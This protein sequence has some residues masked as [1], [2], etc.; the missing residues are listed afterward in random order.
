YT[1]QAI[2]VTVTTVPA[3]LTVSMTYDD[4]AAAPTNAGAYAVRAVVMDSNYSGSVTNTLVIAPAAQNITFGNL[5]E[6]VVGDAPYT[7]TATADSGLPVTFNTSDTSIASTTG[8]L[9]KLWRAG[10]TQITASQNGNGN[11]LAATA[12]TQVVMVTNVVANL[13]IGISHNGVQTLPTDYS[14]TNTVTGYTNIALVI[15]GNPNRPYR[16]EYLTDLTHTNW[17]TLTLISNLP[18]ATYQVIDPVV[19]TGR[20]YRL[21][22]PVWAPTP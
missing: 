10:T 8:N 18:A 13:T 9:L 1:G 22:H 19:P 17:Q 11:Y 20:F 5:P 16:I 4:D 12:V 15:T 21:V 14:L 2:P 3:G 7:L 6:F